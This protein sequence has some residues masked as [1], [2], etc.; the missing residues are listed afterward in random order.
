MTLRIA[1]SLSPFVLAAVTALTPASA[2]TAAPA[3]APPAP[4]QER[5]KKKEAKDFP[6]LLI[7]ARAAWDAGQYG[8]ASAA[9]TEAS[10]LVRK[11]HRA[12]LLEA[13]S[14]AP[15]GWK[16]VPSKQD[17]SAMMI[18]GMA[19]LPIEGRFEG[20]AKERL[21]L[22]LM[23]NSPMVQMMSMAFT[24][25]AMLGKDAEVI[26]YGKHKAVLKKNGNDRYELTI[27]IG[28]DLLQA[29]SRNMTDD[30]VLAICNQAMVNKL[31]AAL[32]K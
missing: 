27:L 32:G 7:S 23:V 18:L 25:P 9:L 15:A 10:K 14:A 3:A 28:G 30:A 26:T 5:A 24:N 31:E 6:G 4:V 29:K 22:S 19:N 12:G 21:D 1:L 16:F 13:M 8:K 11:K 17:D 20:P 2:P